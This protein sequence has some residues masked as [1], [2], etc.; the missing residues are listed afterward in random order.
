[1]ANPETRTISPFSTVTV[2]DYIENRIKENTAES[3]GEAERLAYGNVEQA[4]RIEQALERSVQVGILHSKAIAHARAGKWTN[5]SAEF[6]K[7]V[8]LEP[9]NHA[10]YHS[11][12]A[13]L[14]QGGDVE[15]YHRH[16]AL[17][18]ARFG[19]TNDPVIAG[20]MAEDC[21]ILPGSGL[22]MG[23]V[24][25]LAETAISAGTN[26]RYFPYSQFAKG[27]AGYREGRFGGA[28]GRMEVPLKAG[29]DHAPFLEA[30]ASTVLA[31]AQH[32]LKQPEQARATLAKGVEI[33]LRKLPKLESGD[34]GVDWGDWVIAYALAREAKAL[35]EDQTAPAAPEPK[36]EP[37]IKLAP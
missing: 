23:A 19:A 21:L 22:D 3:L 27:L 10:Y 18:L 15:G 25:K 36:P 9:E 37:Q 29:E 1:M 6:S 16:C 8:E 4:Q 12:A 2:P 32:Q 5:A 14:V 26:H 17:V 13:A 35:I 34:L 20:R 24:G 30:Q 31:M 33:I 28:I 11:L 7:L